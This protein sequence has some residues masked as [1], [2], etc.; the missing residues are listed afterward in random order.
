MSKISIKFSDGTEK[1][2]PHKE[3]TFQSNGNTYDVYL[4]E[5]VDEKYVPNMI[6]ENKIISKNLITYVTDLINKRIQKEV[7]EYNLANGTVFTNVHN[8][9]SY[10]DSTGYTH[11]DFCLSVW[12]WNVAVWEY[13]R[14]ID[15]NS[16]LTEDEL[17]ASLPTRL[18]N[19]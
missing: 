7:D 10:K 11:K 19:A 17:I 14:A 15:V 1:S 6:E 16:T 9:A 18:Q 5:K 3:L 12:N 8:C 13:V 4:S 2:V